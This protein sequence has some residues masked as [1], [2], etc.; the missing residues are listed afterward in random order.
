MASYRQVSSTK[1]LFD[2]PIETVIRCSVPGFK[3]NE[4]GRYFERVWGTDGWLELD[5]SDRDDGENTW[6]SEHIFSMFPNG[7]IV[8]WER[9]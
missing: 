4:H 5:P 2:L 6:I 9:N 7:I 3:G 1:E 8:I